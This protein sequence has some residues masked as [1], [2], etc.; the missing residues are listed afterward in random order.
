MF[1]FDK[2]FKEVLASRKPKTSF[3]KKASSLAPLRSSKTNTLSIVGIDR[4][5]QRDI[6][7]RNIDTNEVTFGINQNEWSFGIEESVAQAPTLFSGEANNES[8]TES[9]GEDGR[10][11]V[12]LFY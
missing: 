1:D 4:A 12:S 6:M 2:Y 8:V 10:F 5:H 11:I 9:N 7:S 3:R